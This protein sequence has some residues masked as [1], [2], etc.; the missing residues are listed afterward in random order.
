MQ[1]DG[2]T[3]TTHMHGN[4]KYKYK[5]DVLFSAIRSTLYQKRGKNTTNSGKI[6][7]GGFEPD[8]LC[9]KK[10]SF[11]II[12]MFYSTWRLVCLHNSFVLKLCL[13]KLMF[14]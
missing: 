2:S 12:A 5:G 14:K 8:L 7:S 4:R 10:N 1:K 13:I 11:S 3:K 6:F 9:T